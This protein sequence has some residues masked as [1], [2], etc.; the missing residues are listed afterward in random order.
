MTFFSSLGSLG[1]SRTFS[2]SS[3]CADALFEMGQ[4]FL[5]VG[6]HVGVGLVGQH[7]FALGDAA[8]Q[9]FVLA[10]LLDHR[11]QFAVRL[12]GLLVALRVGDDLRRSQSA[13]QLF[14]LRF[15]LF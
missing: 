13:V 5:R 1:S 7:G 12:R 11:R 9:V 6:A 15:D 3:T 2:S 10:I 4:L 8:G 14:V